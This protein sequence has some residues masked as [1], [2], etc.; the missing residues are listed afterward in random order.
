MH[1]FVYG[2]LMFEEVWQALVEDRYITLP[3]RI[4]GYRRTRVIDDVYPVIRPAVSGK[5]VP[6]I[7]YLDVSPGDLQRLDQFEGQH[8]ERRQVRALPEDSFRPLRAQ[9]YVLK[10][11]FQ[12]LAS[13]TP[14]DPVKMRQYCGPEFVQRRSAVPAATP[15]YRKPATQ[16]LSSNQPLRIMPAIKP[17]R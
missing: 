3:A 13:Q 15:R 5:A 9:T 4:L 17:V 10:D 16:S 14:W 12:H 6:G 2:T 11:E 1:L 7:V 8:Y